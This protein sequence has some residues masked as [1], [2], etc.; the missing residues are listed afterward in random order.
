MKIIFK[1]LVLIHMIGGTLFAIVLKH[2]H[3][4]QDVKIIIFSLIVLLSLIIFL[5]FVCYMDIQQT[6]R[7]YVWNLCEI[8]ESQNENKADELKIL[9]N[10]DS[11]N[12]FGIGSPN[13]LLWSI[14]AIYVLWGLAAWYF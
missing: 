13:Q 10:R 3:I 11:E 6:I 14:G 8:T 7:S 1:V 12:S 5:I 2:M 4:Q 9:I